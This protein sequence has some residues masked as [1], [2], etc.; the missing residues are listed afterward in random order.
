MKQKGNEYITYHEPGFTAS[1]DYCNTR[2]GSA[3]TIVGE[4]NNVMTIHSEQNDNK[5][6]ILPTTNP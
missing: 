4:R 2:L 6:S 5:N 3:L 1:A